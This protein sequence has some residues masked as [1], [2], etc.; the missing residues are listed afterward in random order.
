LF[1]SAARLRADYQHVKARAPEDALVRDLA[2]YD[3]RFGVD[4][5]TVTGHGASEVAS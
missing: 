1:Q 5:D 4:Y 2:D 3:T